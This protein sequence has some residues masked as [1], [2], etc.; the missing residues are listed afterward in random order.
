MTK[1]LVQLEMNGPAYSDKI[2]RV[3]HR[4]GELLDPAKLTKSILDY[5]EQNRAI[6]DVLEIA[7]PNEKSY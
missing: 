5:F 7:T 1:L 4:V 6:F 3:G 2:N